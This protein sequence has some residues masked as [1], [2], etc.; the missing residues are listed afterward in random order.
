L[1]E[2]RG[3]IMSD[4]ERGKMKVAVV[5]ARAKGG[6]SVS[7]TTKSIQDPGDHG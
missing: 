5:A 3:R 1:I 6:V 7:P 4:D 2:I